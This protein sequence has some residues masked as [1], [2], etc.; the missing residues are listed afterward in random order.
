MGRNWLFK[1]GR[2]GQKVVGSR[3]NLAVLVG[4]ILVGL[5]IQLP[6]LAKDPL[7]S[8]STEQ[9]LASHPPATGQPKAR[10]NT[11]ELVILPGFYRP[12]AESFLVGRVRKRLWLE[13]LTELRQTN[14]KLLVLATGQ[15][16]EDPLD[17]AWIEDSRANNPP[18]KPE[19]A[20]FF[21]RAVSNL[22]FFNS[23]LPLPSLL[24]HPLD[25]AKAQPTHANNPFDSAM[26]VSL[27]L[28]AEQHQPPIQPYVL[29]YPELAAHPVDPLPTADLATPQPPALIFS[30]WTR[31]TRPS[32]FD[33]L[34][35]HPNQPTADQTY[36][37]R[38]LPKLASRL[39]SAHPRQA[40]TIFYIDQS[41]VFPVPLFSGDPANF[42]TPG[43]YQILQTLPFQL[44]L[45]PQRLWK[46]GE[47]MKMQFFQGKS[48]FHFSPL[49]EKALRLDF[50]LEPAT[51]SNPPAWK[52]RATW[53]GLTSPLVSPPPN[54]G[55]EKPP[56]QGTEKPQ[57]SDRN[58][59]AYRW[60]F[61]K[62]TVT[63]R[64]L[65]ACI[66]AWS[67]AALT[68]S[69]KTYAHQTQTA[70]IPS[71]FLLPRSFPSAYP[72]KKGQA[73]T[74]ET[75]ASWVKKDLYLFQFLLEKQEA[76]FLANLFLQQQKKAAGRFLF[77]PPPEDQTF[78]L[79]TGFG[80]PSLFS[81]YL[82]TSRKKPRLIE[83][84][85]R[86]L[87]EDYA[88]SHQPPEACSSFI[89]KL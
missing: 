12:W 1:I 35:T 25:Q 32:F 37:F 10:E 84:S 26:A 38:E 81:S 64:V 56:N 40:F 52:F 29:L 19:K 66:D 11:V 36:L 27:N 71:S 42:T 28:Q 65:Q 79:L 43:V 13:K 30:A 58:S 31:P 73:V 20:L 7:P 86:A 9:L 85:L 76:R 34:P 55:A 24:T 60:V 48:F 3:L 82:Q 23:L 57:P 78:L 54:Q 18:K 33:F 75:L 70:E 67:L 47:Q 74:R 44:F 8:N 39:D 5:F 16:S 63:R 53:I 50:S 2:F 45:L 51:S 14:P 80:A 83:Q 69:A 17:Q 22:D 88:L 41:V 4:T 72:I 46:R 49:Q 61:Q 21:A 87:L 89:R 59:H 6:A 68:E 15:L 77:Q 62:N